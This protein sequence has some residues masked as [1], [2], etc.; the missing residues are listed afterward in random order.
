[1][2]EVPEDLAPRR[3]SPGQRALYLALRLLAL[4]VTKA[5][6]R[7][8]VDGMRNLPPS[9]GY[10]LA[11][12]HRSNL[13]AVLIQVVT[14]RQLRLMG[15]DSLWKAGRFWGWVLTSLGGFPVARGTADRAALRTAQ[16]LLEAGEPVV[17]FPEGTRQSGPRIQTLFD[18]P[19]FLAARCQVPII[20]VGIGGSEAAMGKGAKIPRPRK[21]TFVFGAPL[22]PPAPT[23]TG[24]VARRRVQE[25]T[26]ELYTAVQDQFD[27]AQSRAGQPVLADPEA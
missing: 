2:A 27:Q 24:R 8:D 12:A 23:D 14:R 22:L 16:N 3:F 11:P 19:A 18:G 13:D 5:W 25:L 20:P 26:S 7:I 17:L 9:G 15:K 21:V 4:G 6:F 10:I 1:M